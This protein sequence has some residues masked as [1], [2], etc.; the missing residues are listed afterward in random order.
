MFRTFIFF[1]TFV[2]PQNRAV[3]FTKTTF[4]ASTTEKEEKNK[5][6]SFYLLKINE[7]VMFFE[8]LCGSTVHFL[9]IVLLWFG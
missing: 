7:K 4:Y 3:L 2:S 5:M 9:L 8:E 6:S 1:N